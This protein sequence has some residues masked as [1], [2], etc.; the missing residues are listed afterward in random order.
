MAQIHNARNELEEKLAQATAQRKRDH[1]ANT[2]DDRKAR[3]RGIVGGAIFLAICVIGFILLLNNF[4][5]GLSV[6]TWVYEKLSSAGESI[7][8][9]Q[10][11]GDW[12]ENHFGRTFITVVL[13]IIIFL[14]LFI[15]KILIA[16][17]L[18]LLAIVMPSVVRITMY[19]L[20]LVLGII[21]LLII[22]IHLFW[23]EPT[24][25]ESDD[26]QIIRAGLEG[27]RAALDLMKQLGSNCHVFT[28]LR[29]PFDGGESET[30]LIVVSPA[31]VT[32]IEVKNYKGVISGDASSDSLVQMK[33]GPR[34]R[35]SA[36][37][38]Q[39]PIKQVGTH[40]YRLAGYLR[41]KGIRTFVRCCVLFVSDEVRLS[42]SD[43]SGVTGEKCPVFT[44]ETIQQLFEY[45]SGGKEVLNSV[46]LKRTVKTLDELVEI[47]LGKAAPPSQSLFASP[48]HTDS[49]E[50][51]PSTPKAPARTENTGKPLP[52]PESQARSTTLT[53]PASEEPTPARKTAAPQPVPQPNPGKEAADESR[54][55]RGTGTDSDANNR[56][57][58]G[59]RDLTK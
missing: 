29:I 52:K 1:Q 22:L 31:G 38:V 57:Y 32:I 37:T 47:S 45:V 46:Y 43:N 24:E 2:I 12:L 28:N 10:W 7:M 51:P 49:D 35:S 36:K 26:E 11:G 55:R 4:E 15:P 50:E 30:D 13:D 21:A 54:P 56:E 19:V 34:G 53:P 42:I 3:M 16:L 59:S 41:A 39:N 27:E 9:A 58:F 23:Y 6:R 20:P 8:N 14:I 48:A 33:P 25:Q 17:L 40:V 5:A 18:M 44:R